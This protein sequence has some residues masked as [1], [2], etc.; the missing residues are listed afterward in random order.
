MIEERFIILTEKF[1]D[2][3]LTDN[4]KKELDKFLMDEDYKKEFQNQINVKEAVMNLNLKKPKSEFWDNYWLNTYNR[5]ERGVAWI[6]ISIGLTLLIGFAVFQ[7]IQKLFVDDGGPFII[8]I[9]LIVLFT[10]ALI[11]ILS[12]IREQFIKTKNDSYKEIKR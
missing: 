8:K 9:G 6:L 2:K 12:L 7:F 5:L 11:L 10:G 3:S 4:E 1:I